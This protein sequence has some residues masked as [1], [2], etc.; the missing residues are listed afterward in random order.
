MGIEN[1]ALKGDRWR[2]IGKQIE[3]VLSFISPLLKH[4]WV[5]NS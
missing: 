2:Q 5:Y 3:I 1:D 4:Y